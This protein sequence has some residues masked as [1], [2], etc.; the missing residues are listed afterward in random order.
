MIRWGVIGLGAAGKNHLKVLSGLA[1]VKITGI[2]DLNEV[3]VDQ[4]G[5]LYNVKRS[6]R[7]SD[8]REL[9]AQ[10][11]IDVVSVITGCDT[12]YPIVMEALHH[13]K[14]VLC[15]KPLAP[16]VEECQKMVQTAGQV[17]CLL[18]VSFNYRQNRVMLKIK[19]LIDGNAIGKVQ[20]IR[21]VHL[22]Y[23][24]DFM[25]LKEGASQ[26]LAQN[27][28]RHLMAFGGPIFDCGVHQ[29]DIARVLAKS[30]FTEIEARGY[31]LRGFKYPDYAIAVCKHKNGI[32]TIIENTFIY[33]FHARDYKEHLHRDIIGNEGT[34]TYDLDTQ[35]LE[36]Y[37]P[38][39]TIKEHLPYPSHNE[40][41]L[42]IY[43]EFVGSIREGRLRPTIA[44]GEDGLKAT[45]AALKAVESLMAAG[46]IKR[47]EKGEK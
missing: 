21:L 37:S 9:L 10:Q 23:A 44:S 15:E 5:E 13:R 11:E 3:L 20:I 46:P 33:A 29:F 25:I 18:A 45:E 14:H 2:C 6:G 32:M 8:Y 19:E 47:I 12:H 38:R 30:D 27:R 36:V 39:E 28:L 24:P 26:E 41:R 31:N 35:M 16:T 43:K 17:G 40:D 22:G 42:G 1:D 4:Q 7:F 34:I